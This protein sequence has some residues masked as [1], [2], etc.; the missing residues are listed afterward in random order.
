MRVRYDIKTINGKNYI[1]Q[2][3]LISTKEGPKEFYEFTKPF[4]KNLV[5]EYGKLQW[6][7]RENPD[8]DSETDHMDDRY[9]IEQK[10]IQP[11]T[12]ELEKERKA[13]VKRQLVAELPDIILQN[14]D[15][16]EALVQE[17]CDRAKQ[18]DVEIKN[19]TGRDPKTI[20]PEVS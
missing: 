18:I 10:P 7:I 2:S 19:E 12:E 16:P 20:N 11:T 1:V 5:N 3:Q 6:T 8:Y 4:A 17:L 14:K 13:A 9:I 15:N